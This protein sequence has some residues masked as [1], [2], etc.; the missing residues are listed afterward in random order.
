MGTPVNL[1]VSYMGQNT[2]QLQ[3]ILL[4]VEFSQKFWTG[5]VLFFIMTL[6]PS[7]WNSTRTTLP[8]VSSLENW[9]C[10]P[11][12]F[13]HLTHFI[14]QKKI[15]KKKHYD[16]WGLISGSNSAGQLPV[17]SKS[18]TSVLLSLRKEKHLLNKK[19]VRKIPRKGLRVIIKMNRALYSLALHNPKQCMP[20][21]GARFS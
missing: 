4:N 14:T 5:L 21:L 16:L 18:I 3:K 12:R 17:P 15:I 10:Q 6:H 2:L 19:M 11:T 8:E 20:S 9:K 1:T 7:N 13:K